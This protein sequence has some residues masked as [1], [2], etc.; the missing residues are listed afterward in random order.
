MTNTDNTDQSVLRDLRKLVPDRPVRVSEGLAI[1]DGIAAK[2]RTLA[3]DRGAHTPEDLISQI[4]SIQIQ[5]RD[6]LVDAETSWWPLERQWVIR[7][8]RRTD[9][10]DQQFALLREFARIIWQPFEAI[11]PWLHRTILEQVAGHAA[12]RFAA[13]VLVPTAQLRQAQQAGIVDAVAL[14]DRFG[15]TPDTIRWKLHDLNSG[16][17]TARNPKRAL[18]GDEAA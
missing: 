4:A 15:V 9:P 11:Y 2:F 13:E 8:N 1:I 16:L 5:R 18:P 12:D 14:A 10:R 17:P 6:L 3:Q 7:L